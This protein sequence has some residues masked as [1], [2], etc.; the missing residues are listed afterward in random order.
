MTYT[1]ESAVQRLLDSY[2]TYYDITLF[3]DERRPLTA[4]CEYYESARKYVLSHKAELWAENSEEFIFLFQMD[5][6]TRPIY[7][8]CRDYAL[9]EGM[10]RAHIGPGHMYTYIT[11]VFVCNE[12]NEEARKALRKTCIYK[13]FRFSFHG[14]MDVHTAVLEV[15]QNKISA[16]AGGIPVKKGMK[17]V[18]FNPDKSS[19]KL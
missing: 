13:S 8:Q 17:R 9:E 12:C 2:Q 18:L 7:E 6:L 4:I 3:A 11:P 5:H 15:S 19:K 10:K 14:W 16:N 1:V